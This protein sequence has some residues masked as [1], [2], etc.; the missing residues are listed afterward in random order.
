MNFLANPIEYLYT[1]RFLD[2]DRS[3]STL[4]GNQQA[5]PG[6][7]RLFMETSRPLFLGEDGPRSHSPA[8]GSQVSR[9]PPWFSQAPP[10]GPRFDVSLFTRVPWEMSVVSEGFGGALCRE[11]EA[12]GLVGSLSEGRCS[13][14][15]LA[16]WSPQ[17]R[18]LIAGVFPS[19]QSK[20]P[21]GLVLTPT[22]E[23]A[24]QIERQAKELMSGLPCLRTALLV[25]GLPAPPQRHRLRQRIQV[26][27]L[28]RAPL[29][30]TETVQ[31]PRLFS[32]GGALEC[33][34]R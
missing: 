30:R 27:L 12:V 26:G 7:T 11:Q 13:W 32:P 1:M 8:D 21:S 19:L 2:K 34:F 31:E 29:Q 16:D 23:L 20:S 24:I 14:D 17:Q 18:Q 15:C 28:D 10:A 5:M 4:R 9:L 33:G 3:E 25:G 22:R 6:L